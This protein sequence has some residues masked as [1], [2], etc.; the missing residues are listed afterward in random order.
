MKMYLDSLDPFYSIDHEPKL[1]PKKD[2]AGIGAVIF[3]FTVISIVIGLSIFTAWQTAYGFVDGNNNGRDDVE[4]WQNSGNTEELNTTNILN[5]TE[6]IKNP[7]ESEKPRTYED[8]YSENMG[9]L[10]LA[11]VFAPKKDISVTDLLDPA[12]K[13]TIINMCNFYHEKTGIW[14]NMMKDTEILN[15]YKSEFYQKYGNEMPEK[16]KQMI[17]EQGNNNE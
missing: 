8:C 1:K 16:L 2:Y 5:T 14:F 12:W 4:E 6:A 3:T 13:N 15:P 7:V 10:T 17:Q 9:L 11:I